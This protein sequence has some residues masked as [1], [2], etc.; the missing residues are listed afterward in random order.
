MQDL[1][2]ELITIT[3]LAKLLRRCRTSIRADIREGRLPTPIAVG[4]R[5]RVWLRRDVLDFLNAN[6]RQANPRNEG[7]AV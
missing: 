3:E 4:P 1:D 2:I 5:H 6:R 7:G